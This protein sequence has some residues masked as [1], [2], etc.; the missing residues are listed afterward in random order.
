MGEE[1]WKLNEWDGGGGIGKNQAFSPF[2]IYL[3]TGISRRGRKEKIENKN[4]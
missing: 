3:K 4:A 1:D 2:L